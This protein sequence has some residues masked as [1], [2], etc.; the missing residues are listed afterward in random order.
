MTTLFPIWSYLIHVITMCLVIG[1][2][3][4]IS[5]VL[6]RPG[7]TPQAAIIFEFFD[8]LLSSMAWVIFSL[9]CPVVGV[10][11][12][13]TSLLTIIALRLFLAP[14]FLGSTHFNPCVTLYQYLL[15]V[16]V[17][18]GSEVKK[19]SLTTSLLH[20]LAEILAIPLGSLF[21]ILTWTALAENDLSSDHIYFMNAQP[22]FFLSVSSPTGFVIELSISFVMFLLAI[23]LP[24]TRI[25][26]ISQVLLMTFLI[27][28]FGSMTGAF[29]NP[30]AALTFLLMWHRGILGPSSLASHFFV[31]WL[32]PLVGTA[33]AVGV[34]RTYFIQKSRVE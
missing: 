18:S 23:L 7:G 13:K 6:K 25:Y 11:W 33:M 15:G 30:I 27:S 8:E 20:L 5:A 10:A 4:A 32:G 3:S 29:I 17:D 12:S 28:I 26:R 1:C 16:G 2:K 14:P 19:P 24:D 31:F 21:S 22:E 34:V 9:E